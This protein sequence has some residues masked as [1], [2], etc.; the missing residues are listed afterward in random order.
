MCT[1]RSLLAALLLSSA[2]A[3]AQPAPN[4]T[5]PDDVCLDCTK[6]TLWSSET[7]VLWAGV[8]EAC[9]GCEALPLV[10]N[11]TGP[12]E[13]VDAVVSCLHGPFRL[14]ARDPE[15]SAALA[16]L[17]LDCGDRGAVRVLL[18]RSG[19]NSTEQ[20]LEVVEDV[21]PVPGWPV[22]AIAAAMI[23]CGFAGY[24]V[25]ALT[26]RVLH[27]RLW[28]CK[29][30]DLTGTTIVTDASPGAARPLLSSDPVPPLPLSL[31]MSLPISTNSPTPGEV[32]APTAAQQQ[33]QQPQQK[34]PRMV[35]VDVFRGL[36]LVLMIFVNYGGGGFYV[37]GHAVW[38]GLLVA[39][40]VFPWFVFVMGVTVSLSTKSTVYGAAAPMTSEQRNTALYRLFIR[41]VKL[42]AL[43]LF[44][45][46][47]FNTGTWRIPGVLQ[48]FAFAYGVIMLLGMLC[49]KC[50]ACSVDRGLA[51]ASQSSSRVERIK[52][53]FVDVVPYVYE[54]L[55]I[56]GLVLLH[57][58][59]TFLVK[60]PGCP[61]GYIGPGGMVDGGIYEQ[62]TG[63]V[64][65]LIDR[66]VFGSHMYQ[67]ALCREMYHTMPHDPEGLLGSLNTVVLC[68]LGLQAGRIFAHYS[69]SR[70]HCIR[71]AI[72]GVASGVL[73]LALA[74]G[75][76]TGGPVPINKNLWSISFVLVNS[77]LCYAMMIVCYLTVDVWKWWLGSPFRFVGM[78]SIVLYAV[79]LLFQ[80]LFPF[81]FPAPD[82][83]AWFLARNVFGISTCCIIAFVLYL[84]RIFITV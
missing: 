35:S 24:E 71:W 67:R 18:Q 60:L 14:E 13:A 32:A 17:L 70:S 22:I 6:V 65:N 75:R 30:L 26:F 73:G 25:G 83:H 56:A 3:W 45:S 33:R 49:P 52:R 81:D 77:A 37:F 55:F 69:D 8:S 27:E 63:G 9:E 11:A 12:G 79:H 78:N 64:A 7:R 31:S 80:G 43:G 4:V 44:L 29:V 59:V 36:T 51:S 84:K 47:G 42:F 40:L 20:K 2:L 16:V 28:P 21:A 1:A 19:D 82:T 61:R 57:S 23:A 54:Y 58:G 46:N 48:R 53:S 50:G 34:K 76:G 38:D 41:C 62:C 66:T 10:P 72:W 39:D 74:F 68:F 5:R 15:T